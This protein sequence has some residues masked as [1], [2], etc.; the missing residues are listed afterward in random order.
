MRAVGVKKLKQPT[1]RFYK[2]T[3]CMVA[4]FIK[5]SPLQST[6]FFVEGVDLHVNGNSINE[7]FGEILP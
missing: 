2:P 6:D 5:L 3:N 1:T 7:L 4:T